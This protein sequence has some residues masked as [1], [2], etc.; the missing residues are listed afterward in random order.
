VGDGSACG[1]KAGV[2]NGHELHLWQRQ[3]V[4]DRNRAQALARA[5]IRGG[6]VLA[7]AVESGR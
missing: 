1:G 6:G 3:H 5:V 2:E 4:L 7:E